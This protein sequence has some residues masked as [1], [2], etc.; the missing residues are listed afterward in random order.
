MIA[1]FWILIPCKYPGARYQILL[2]FGTFS[3]FTAFRYML[4]PFNCTFKKASKSL[5]IL[6]L[7]RQTFLRTK[8]CYIHIGCGLLSDQSGS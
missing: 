3:K 5:H 2:K 4:D 1:T 6:R 7:T 8:K